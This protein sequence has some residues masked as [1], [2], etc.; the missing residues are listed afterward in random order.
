MNGTLE[1][2]AERIR[3]ADPDDIDE[4]LR[5]A[6]PLIYRWALVRTADADDAEDV[7]QTVLLRV[8]DRIHEFRGDANFT[9]WLYRVTANAAAELH[10]RRGAFRRSL[11]KWWQRAVHDAS[12][13]DD[14]LRSI[15]DGR[16]RD[17]IAHMLGALTRPQRTILDL[18]DLQDFTPAEAADMLEMNANT[19]RVHL[20]RAR[21][22][23]RRRLLKQYNAS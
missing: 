4:L 15:D 5:R 12:P 1:P 18:V 22:I 23:V 19:A 11:T 8:N 21:R 6:R 13:A 9:T 10:R 2:L 16:L 7:T 20:M 14:A 17:R 3:S